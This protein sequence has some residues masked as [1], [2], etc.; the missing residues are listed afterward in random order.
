MLARSRGVE[1]HEATDVRV[2]DSAVV[3]RYHASMKNRAFL[4]APSSV[5]VHLG[6]SA[7]LPTT[8]DFLLS[9][10]RFQQRGHMTPC[11]VASS[12]TELDHLQD[13]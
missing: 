13:T 12:T 1:K 4:F 11:A 9:Q 5:W 3:F 8:S 7:V 6:A 2:E 10:R